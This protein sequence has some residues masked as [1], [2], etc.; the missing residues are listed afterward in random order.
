MISLLEAIKIS[1]LQMNALSL[2][3]LIIIWLSFRKR[4]DL[5]NTRS[6]IFMWLLNL[7]AIILL[8]DC[9]SVCLYEVPGVFINIVLTISTILYYALIPLLSLFWM[10]YVHHHFYLDEVIQK[11][12][13]CLG[14]IP[15]SIHALL[16]IGSVWGGWFFYF[17]PDNAYYRGDF[18]WILPLLSFGYI[19]TAFA[20][21]LKNRNHMPTK[22]WFPL[23]FF[24]IPAVI[25]TVLQILFFG[26]ATIL[27]SIAVSLLIIFVFIQKL[28][29][30]TDHLTG[31]YNR[32]EFDYYLEDWIKW[33]NENKKIAGF[34]VDI[35]DFKTINDSFGHQTGDEALVAISQ[36]LRKSFRVNDFVAR[37]GGDEFAVVLEVNEL[38]EVEVLKKR[39]LKNVEVFNEENGLYSLSVSCG[40]GV[41]DPQ[42]EK[43]VKDFFKKLDERMYKEKHEKKISSETIQQPEFLL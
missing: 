30:N 5:S 31:L 20:I 19:F 32:R 2:I 40:S 16:S 14:M 28:S 24:G 29:I 1:T 8:M 33:K 18:F 27:P 11:K 21:V 34:M 17:G 12:V 35:D 39:L 4:A 3:I 23:L 38:E 10:S 15:V 9:I 6:R 37:I 22:S 41:F 7:N 26:L 25:G 36:V 42:E 43:T 13:F